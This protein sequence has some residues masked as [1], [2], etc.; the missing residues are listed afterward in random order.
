MRN[1]V[2]AV[3]FAIIAV[4]V[5]WDWQPV[6]RILVALFSGLVIIYELATSKEMDKPEPAHFTGRRYGVGALFLAFCFGYLAWWSGAFWPTWPMGI[7]IAIGVYAFAYL[8]GRAK[9][10]ANLKRLGL[11]EHQS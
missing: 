4:F 10:R 5:S 3:S 9:G 1:F 2:F 11:T 7:A 8:I 6:N